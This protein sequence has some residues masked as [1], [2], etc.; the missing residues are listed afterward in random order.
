MSTPCHLCGDDIG[1]DDFLSDVHADCFADCRCL[2]CTEL[3]QQMAEDRSA[4]MAYEIWR[5]TA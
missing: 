4:D 1:A 5:E 2:S 3:R